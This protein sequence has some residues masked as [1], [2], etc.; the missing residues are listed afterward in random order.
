MT[1]HIGYNLLIVLSAAVTLLLL[2]LMLLS[3]V[4][5]AAEVPLSVREEFIASSSLL[6]KGSDRYLV[7]VQG[8]LINLGDTP[9]QVD[10]LKLCIGDGDTEWE[11]VKEGFSLP[12]RFERPFLYEW[13]DTVPYDRVLSVVAV[14]NGEELP[15]ANSTADAPFN[16]SALIYAGLT[17][18]AAWALL[19]VSK[20][21]YYLA[22]ADRMPAVSETKD[23]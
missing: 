4:G 17:L 2:V 16:I 12:V 7:Q 9:L 22:Q 19:T 3:L 15:L 23:A 20:Q 13:E 14:C 10:A 1:K 8:S 21:R 5:D 11:L 6:E 18:L